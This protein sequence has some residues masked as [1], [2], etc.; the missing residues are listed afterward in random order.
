MARQSGS[1]PSTATKA[2]TARRFYDS[3]PALLRIF[4]DASTTL[5]RLVFDSSTTL[6]QLFHDSEL[7]PGSY[8]ANPPFDRASVEGTFA[9]AARALARTQPQG[10]RHALSLVVVV[11]RFD[12]W[13]AQAD[14]PGLARFVRASATIEPRQ[15]IFQMGMQHR[16]TGPRG[17]D[18]RV[19]TSTFVTRVYVLQ[20]D[21][22]ARRWPATDARVERLVE[23][24][25]GDPGDAPPP[26]AG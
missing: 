16:R 6:L 4:Y 15:H 22:G 24:F 10:A 3:P 14:V 8:E 23:S 21:A 11:P 9:H 26:A 25:R 7:K 2:A 20:N 18:E 17:T 12:G 5:L 13:E 1:R 19:W